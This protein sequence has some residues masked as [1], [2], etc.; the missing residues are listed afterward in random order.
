MSDIRSHEVLRLLRIVSKDGVDENNLRLFLIDSLQGIGERFEKLISFLESIDLL[1]LENGQMFATID[2]NKVT[3]ELIISKIFSSKKYSSEFVSFCQSV[4]LISKKHKIVNLN[5]SR[6]SKEFL[7]FVLL[8]KQ[9]GV[10]IEDQKPIYRLNSEWFDEFMTFISLSSFHLNSGNS[11]SPQQH[12]M[13]VQKNLEIGLAAE[14]FVIK[15]EKARLA[16]HPLVDKITHVAV[17]NTAAGFDI[18]S[19]DNVEDLNPNRK[20]EVKSWIDKKVFFFSANEFAVAAEAKEDYFLYLVDRKKMNN[21]GYYPEVIRNP[22]E[23]IFQK[24]NSWKIRS[25]GWKIEQINLPN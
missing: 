16:N 11:V 17:V 21:S 5:F 19:F 15:I 22:V 7:W 23:N 18:L 12:A 14:Q 24:E 2:S 1:V 8:L 13:N 6:V 4:K 20:I 9:L 10:L 25:D 3:N